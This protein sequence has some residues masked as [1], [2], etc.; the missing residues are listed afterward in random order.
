SPAEVRAALRG[1]GADGSATL[2]LLRGG[3]ER[4]VTARFGETGTG[5]PGAPGGEAPALPGR[6]VAR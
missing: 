1:K 3:E 5:K 6:P 2:T 4:E